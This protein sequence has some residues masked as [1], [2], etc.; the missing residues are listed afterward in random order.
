[1]RIMLSACRIGLC[2]KYWIN[3]NWQPRCGY[4]NLG[5]HWPCK[6]C[7]QHLSSP[8]EVSRGA[9]KSNG[10]Q[11]AAGR[12]RLMTVGREIWC[13]HA[14]LSPLTVQIVCAAPHEALARCKTVVDGSR[15]VFAPK[16]IL[17]PKFE[18]IW[19]VGPAWLGAIGLSSTSWYLARWRE[20]LHTQFARSM[21]TKVVVATTW[22]LVGNGVIEEATERLCSAKSK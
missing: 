10:S 21:V 20:V 14:F 15:N 22:L 5:R 1:M 12:G 13:Q 16:C 17:A 7:E 19:L 8:R 9:R 3:P 18:A 4:H 2:I 6:L 11:S